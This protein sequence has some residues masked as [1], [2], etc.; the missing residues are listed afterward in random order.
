M[1]PIIAT[2]FLAIAAFAHAATAASELVYH[3]ATVITMDDAMPVAAAVGV[4]DGL[5][6][7][8]GALPEV[9]EKTGPEVRKIDLGGKTLVPGFVDSHGHAYLIGLQAISA[10]LLPPPDG[11]GKDAASVVSLLKAWAKD[12][13]EIVDEIG[14]IVGFGYDDS[15]LATQQH[16]TRDDLDKV[17]TEKPVIIIHQSGH[18]GVANSKA[19]EIAGVDAATQDPD[20]GV[21]RRRQG[22]QE[23][24]GVMEEYAFFQVLFGLVSNFDDAF[25]ERLVIEGTRLAASFGYTTVQEGRATGEGLAAIQRVAA[26]GALAVDLVSYPDVLEVKDPA[27]SLEYKN[28]YRVGGVK[29]TIDGSPQGKT[30]WLSHPYFVPPQGQSEDYRGYAAIDEETTKA[31]VEKAY[32]NGWQ[33]LVHSNG[34]AATDRLIDAIRAAKS[35]HPEVDNRPV[36]I[37]GQVL[38]EE[39]VEALRELGVF[40]SLFPM[41]TFYWGDWHRQSVL[42]AERA[43]NISPTGWVLARGMRFGTH[44]DAPVALPD[45]MRVLSATVTRTTR[46]GYVLGPEHRVPVATALKAMTL[47]PAWQH[48]EEASKGSISPGKLA[49]FAVLSANPLQV[50]ESKLADIEVLQ[51]IKEGEVVYRRETPSGQAAS[52]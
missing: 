19:L 42:G 47:W 38:R 23:L 18:L 9:L 45:S 39:Q 41:H 13:P 20:G 27:P 32:A 12:N 5:I 7:A 16:P 43:E 4:R 51:T 36:L 6:V 44:H 8:V 49:D 25:N 35:R 21:F 48:F 34:D 29:L 52:K 26:R 30:A 1:K 22:S 15:Q 50:D 2:G 46:S 40:P 17:S 14:W 31:A 10:N 37:H 28:R 11:Q 33:I 3:N 24:N